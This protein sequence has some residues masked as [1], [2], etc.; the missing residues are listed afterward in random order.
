M[1]TFWQQALA[2]EEYLR[3]ERDTIME[4]RQQQKEK[5]KLMQLQ[6]EIGRREKS[7]KVIL[8]DDEIENIAKLHVDSQQRVGVHNAKSLERS[9]LSF[10]GIAS[11][12]GPKRGSRLSLSILNRFGGMGKRSLSTDKLQQHQDISE[13]NLSQNKIP[14]S[15]SMPTMHDLLNHDVV[16]KVACDDQAEQHFIIDIQQVDGSDDHKDRNNGMDV[17][18]S[19]HSETSIIMI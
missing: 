5:N 10:P 9:S 12:L 15:P 3:K 11:P 18:S 17:S 14:L 4:L 13:D 19:D 16:G 2:R 8:A 6:R 7:A 1:F